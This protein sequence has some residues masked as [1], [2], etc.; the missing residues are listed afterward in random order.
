MFISLCLF[1]ML[2]CLKPSWMFQRNG[3]RSA[4][5][6]QNNSNVPFCLY[7][8][9][10]LLF[11]RLS[12]S[13]LNQS[14]FKQHTTQTP[15][16]QIRIFVTG[17]MVLQSSRDATLSLKFFV[18][19]CEFCFC[20]SECFWD[21]F[22]MFIWCFCLVFVNWRTLGFARPELTIHFFLHEQNTAHLL[23]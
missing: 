20:A 12:G 9:S 19:C 16:N 21:I 2:L 1:I 5:S 22:T 6:F 13:V 4:S 15:S 17:N 14:Y 11:V 8:F 23:Q 10:S 7:Y 18:V 3:N